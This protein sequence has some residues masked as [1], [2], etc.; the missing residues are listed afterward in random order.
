MIGAGE[1]GR[2]NAQQRKEASEKHDGAAPAIK[3]ILTETQFLRP[4][5]HIMAV[6]FEQL[7]AEL[8]AEPIADIVSNDRAGRRRDH[9]IFDNH[10]PGEPSE[11]RC[12]D[13]H[14]FARQ[15]KAG[16]FKR[17]DEKNRPVA[18]GR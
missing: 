12:A 5:S 11:Y 1:R 17:D 16:A 6:T 15:G 18:V 8:P 4:K 2:E 9:D 7:G 13:Q 14:G 3:E 10:R